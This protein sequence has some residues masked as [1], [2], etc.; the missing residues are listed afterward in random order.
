MQDSGE[1]GKGGLQR[2]ATEA[3]WCEGTEGVKVRKEKKREGWNVDQGMD[4]NGMKGR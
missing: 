3:G 2:Q 1:A 4:W